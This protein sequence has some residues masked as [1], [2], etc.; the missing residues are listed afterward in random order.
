MGAA[1]IGDDSPVRMR[2]MGQRSNF[3]N[4]R[5]AHLDNSDVVRGLEFEQLQGHT[6]FVVEVTLRLEDGEAGSEYCRNRFF[7]C[8]FAGAAGDANHALVPV[9]AH[10]GGKGLQGGEWVVDDQKRMGMSDAKKVGHFA[11][12]NDGGPCTMIESRGDKIMRVISLTPHSEEEISGSERTRIDRIA[13]YQLLVGI[14]GST[15]ELGA[16]PGRDVLK[17]KFHWHRP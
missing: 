9:P 10:S 15:P 5:H 2:N 11:A 12:G 6:V 3:S 8:G 14:C 17:L 4:V 7:S 1:D 13:G 16:G